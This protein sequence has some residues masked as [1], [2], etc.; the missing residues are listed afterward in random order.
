MDPVAKIAQATI[1]ENFNNYIRKL[2]EQQ[3]VE[4]SRNLT[5]GHIDSSYQNGSKELTRLRLGYGAAAPA[6]KTSRVKVK[7]P[8]MRHGTTRSKRSSARQPEEGRVSVAK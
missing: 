1:E 2:N 8:G 5:T 6:K 3:D 7:S 4:T